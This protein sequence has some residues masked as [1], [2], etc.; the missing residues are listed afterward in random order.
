MG[1]LWL[2]R[3][4]WVWRTATC[5]AAASVP[6]A[7]TTSVSTAGH[8]PATRAAGAEKKATI[9]IRVAEKIVAIAENCIYFCWLIGSIFFLRVKAF[10]A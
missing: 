7:A 3:R 9:V 5:T 2:W 6:S 4:L 8:V 1:G 10:L